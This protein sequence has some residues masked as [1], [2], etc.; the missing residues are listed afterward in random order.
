[1]V[2]FNVITSILQWPQ[3]V[4]TRI[5]ESRERNCAT[6]SDDYSAHRIYHFYG[7]VCWGKQV[8][9]SRFHPKHRHP[10][11]D[12]AQRHIG[13]RRGVDA[14]ELVARATAWTNNSH[15]SRNL[16]RH[17]PASHTAASQ[18]NHWFVVVVGVQVS[19]FGAGVRVGTML[20]RL[21]TNCVNQRM[22]SVFR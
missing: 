11:G 20:L 13:T 6:E 3:Q 9:Q 18:L 10:R 22:I 16:S 1:V 5:I 4:E 15:R 12:A 2:W 21:Y 8:P 17:V 14:A 19:T 7:G